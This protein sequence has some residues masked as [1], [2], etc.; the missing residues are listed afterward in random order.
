MVLQSVVDIDPARLTEGLAG[1][2]AHFLLKA[3]QQALVVDAHGFEEAHL[4]LLTITT[5]LGCKTI[6]LALQLLF[7]DVSLAKLL[8]R[9][10]GLNDFVV[11][12]L[13]VLDHLGDHDFILSHKRLKLM[14]L[15]F[16]LPAITLVLE[17][18]VNFVLNVTLGV[19]LGGFLTRISTG[20]I[21]RRKLGLL[22]RRDTTV[23]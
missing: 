11:R 2:V 5:K 14:L 8:Q 3:A 20:F 21:R 7:G 12:V 19:D 1:L 23:L 16:A 18:H 17:R 22:W 9:C 4:Q 15:S 10:L 13:V 6:S